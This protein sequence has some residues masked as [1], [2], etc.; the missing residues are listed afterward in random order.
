MCLQYGLLPWRTKETI[1]P[2]N[3]S[4]LQVDIYLYILKI[5]T[6][7]LESILKSAN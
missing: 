6:L 1:K 5:H 3:M 7:D 4:K 2:S